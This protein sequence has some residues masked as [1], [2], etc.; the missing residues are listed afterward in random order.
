MTAEVP[1]ADLP[2]ALQRLADRNVVGKL[3]MVP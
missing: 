2:A 3:V 1:Y